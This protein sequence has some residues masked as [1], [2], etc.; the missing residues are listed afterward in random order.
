V[1]ALTSDRNTPTAIGDARQ[2][3]VAAGQKVFAGALVM[4]NAAGYLVKGVTG[5]NLT[6]VGRAEDQVDNTAGSDGDV[7]LAFRPGL[8]RFAN[9]GSDTITIADIG[10]PCYAVDDQT[11]ARTDGTGTRS[12]AGIVEMLDTQGVWVSFNEAVTRAAT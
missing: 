11:V 12:K 9:D 1:T 6:G 10:L 5:L 4:R 8:F 2:G 3:A 7:S